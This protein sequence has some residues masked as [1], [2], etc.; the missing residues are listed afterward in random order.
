MKYQ[1]K[2]GVRSRVL[3]SLSRLMC[4]QIDASRND[5]TPSPTTASFIHSDWQPKT[6]HIKQKTS[7]IEPT[8]RYTSNAHQLFRSSACAGIHR[9]R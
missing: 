8:K 1:K 6:I 4:S 2:P 3:I 9:H 5:L 7:E